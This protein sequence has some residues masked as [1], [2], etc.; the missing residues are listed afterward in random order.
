M[1]EEEIEEELEEEV[2]EGIEEEEVCPGCGLPLS[3]CICEEVEEEE[4]E[5]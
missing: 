3:E 4:F 5:E 1:A 2:E